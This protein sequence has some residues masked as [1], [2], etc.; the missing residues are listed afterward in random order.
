MVEGRF[1]DW[2]LYL[3]QTLVSQDGCIQQGFLACRGC[4]ARYPIVDGVA[5]I[6]ADVASWIRQQERPLLHRSDLDPQLS[7]WLLGSWPDDQDPSW[8]RQM[9]ATYAHGFQ[10][11][12][13]E[14]DPFT[15]SMRA[16]ALQ[17]RDWLAARRAAL[18]AAVGEAPLVLDAGC[19]V[20]VGTLSMASSGA[21]VVALDHDFGSLRLLSRLLLAGRATVPHW[22]HGGFDYVPVEITAPA[23]IDASRIALIAADACRPPFRARGF[24]VV[25]AD[26]LVDNVSDPVLL[27]R[28]LAALLR[29]GGSLSLS[30]PYD[31]V[32]R[33]VPRG[34]RL[35]ESLR[36]H[37]DA[38][39]DPAVAM[40][41]LLRGELSQAPELSF[42][43][44]YERRDLPW[45]LRRHNRSIHAFVCHYLE[46]SKASEAP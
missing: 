4:P 5:I 43:V 27:I 37:A 32:S 46:A 29:G 2:P 7:G 31:W 12:S 13:A 14:A 16:Q 41:E 34:K 24:D 35:G 15:R 19:S 40:L 36:V 17:S 22:R 39:P 8:R 9:L 25:V 44:A 23:G 45:V 1:V 11:D 26:N 6:F 3:A 33:C 30:T 20:G 10:A 18:I 21:R 28:Q 42:Q 38:E